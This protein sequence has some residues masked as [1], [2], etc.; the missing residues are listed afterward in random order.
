VAFPTETAYGLAANTE[1]LAAVAPVVPY[2]LPKLA[3]GRGDALLRAVTSPVC[4]APKDLVHAFL[5]DPATLQRGP[6]T[7][8]RMGGGD[9]AFVRATGQRGLAGT[10]DLS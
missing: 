2:G 1:D 8:D 9:G 3:D 5:A 7:G 6:S 10:W 4:G